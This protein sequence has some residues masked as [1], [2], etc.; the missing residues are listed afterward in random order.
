MRLSHL[1]AIA[2]V[3]FGL[4]TG[5]ALAGPDYPNNAPAAQPETLGTHQAREI[6][7]RA[8]R[9]GDG[10]L[11]EQRSVASAAGCIIGPQRAGRACHGDLPEQPAE[12]LT[13]GPAT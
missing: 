4:G 1:T 9:A 6:P 12:R 10:G 5:A 8:G 13:S 7:S 3:A 2:A 11:S